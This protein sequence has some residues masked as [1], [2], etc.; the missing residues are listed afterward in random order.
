MPGEASGKDLVA[1]VDSVGADAVSGLRQDVVQ[2]SRIS[3]VSRPVCYLYLSILECLI[4]YINDLKGICLGAF[5][6]FSAAVLDT[7]S[8]SKSVEMWREVH[9]FPAF[10]FKI[11]VQLLRFMR[12]K[13]CSALSL[14]Q[15][16]LPVAQQLAMCLPF[17]LPWSTCEFVVYCL[18][19]DR[20]LRRSVSTTQAQLWGREPF[21]VSW[22]Y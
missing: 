4:G 20:N 21:Y 19:L 9:I 11:A 18:D 8:W 1:C 13:V 15:C 6:V 14:S 16:A 22:S 17:L 10:L 3:E 7:H 12:L 2:T 5:N